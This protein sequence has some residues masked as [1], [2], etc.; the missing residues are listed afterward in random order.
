M[1]MHLQEELLGSL[2]RDPIVEVIFPT[3]FQL[4]MGRKRTSHRHHYKI[5]GGTW[6]LESMKKTK[7][8]RY[9]LSLNCEFPL[10]SSETGQEIVR[11]QFV[12]V[13]YIQMCI[14]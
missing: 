10:R 3:K 8:S 4:F 6:G 1:H 11:E 13:R 14:H 7:C 12:L 2:T 9:Y 5:E